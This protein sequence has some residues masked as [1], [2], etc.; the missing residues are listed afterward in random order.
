MTPDP[1]PVASAPPTPSPELPPLVLVDRADRL[2]DRLASVGADALLLTDPIEV[3]WC[4]GFTGSAGWVAVLADRVVLGTDARYGERAADEL[5]AVG[6]DGAVE[7]VVDPTRGARRERIVR[8]LHGAR[9]VGASATRTS[10]A[11]WTDLSTDLALV[12]ADEVTASVR[13]IKDAAELA[14]IARAATLA[15][16]ALAEVAPRLG[17]G[18]TERDV[19]DELEHRMRVLGA[20]GPSYDTIVA[21]GPDN[22]ARPHHHAERRR[23]V[24]GDLVV[25]DV[26]ALVDGYHSDMT[27]TFVIG[28]PSTAQRERYELVS[29]C[30]RAGLAAVAPG[31][32]AGEVDRA[33]RAVAIAAGLGD[34][35]LHG[36]GHG[37]GLEIH[38][39]P[40]C[41]PGS[42]SELLAGDVVTVEP[43]LYR[44]GVGGVR[45]EDLVVVTTTGPHILTESPKDDPCLP[46]P[47][48][49]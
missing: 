38:E 40:M 8:T 37:V 5:A 47:P 32:T 28:D 6:L 34:E 36:T 43:G 2:R 14:R 30:Q 20:D 26:G 25:I 10:H 45:I 35:Y 39:A 9:T 27:R 19:H 4:T 31:V 17:D 42:S 3:A 29:E 24:E 48:T 21:S 41:V 15:D 22:A 7:L 16:R 49:T 44:A 12:P 1:A 23:I 33:A 11:E 18:L 13:R 46:S